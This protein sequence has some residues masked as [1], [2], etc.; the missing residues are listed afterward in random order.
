MPPDPAVRRDQALLIGHGALV[1][2]VA[3]L[4]GFGLTFALLGEVTLWPIPW[5]TDFS[6]G[7]VR[8]WRAAHVGGLLNGVMMIVLALG[9][10]V[11]L[12]GRRARKWTVW[13]LI[14]TGWGNTVFYLLGNLAPNR[15][16][17]G[18]GTPFGE[19]TLLGLFAYLPA[20]TATVLAMS[21]VCI[22]TLGAF[23]AMRNGGAPPK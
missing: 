11:L 6:V 23:R 16:L 2:L 17:S 18:G 19:G 21:A 3:L 12:L 5:S 15:G 20:A 14:Y 1:L 13:T 4:A 10:P 22:I 9:L 8:G 7:S